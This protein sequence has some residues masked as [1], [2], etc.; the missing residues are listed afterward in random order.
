LGPLSVSAVPIGASPISAAMI[1]SPTIFIFYIRL[2]KKH[3]V[4]LRHSQDK[5]VLGAAFK[6]D[7]L[8]K[9]V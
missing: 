4:R 7:L 3:N 8:Q 9:L 6:K 1:A 5:I 2:H